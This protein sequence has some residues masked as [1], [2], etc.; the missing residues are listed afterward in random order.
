MHRMS[1]ETF[2]KLDIPANDLEVV[3]L[4]PEQKA[5]FEKITKRA[6]DGGE[7]EHAQDFRMDYND[8]EFGAYYLN[9]SIR[10]ILRLL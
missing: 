1:T 7:W 3:M 10:P 8:L 9:K 6:T 2:K 4:T 5:M